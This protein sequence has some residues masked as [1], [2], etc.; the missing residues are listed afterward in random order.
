[1]TSRVKILES[2]SIPYTSTFPTHSKWDGQA[3]LCSEECTVRP[4]S[5]DIV[6]VT[7]TTG[8]LGSAILAKLVASDN[9]GRIYALNRKSKQGICL[10]ERQKQALSSRGYDPNIVLSPKVVLVEGDFMRSGLEI[11]HVLKEEAC[12]VVISLI[13]LI[14]TMSFRYVKALLIY[15][16]SVSFMQLIPVKNEALIIP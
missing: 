4:D 1:M 2:F 7:G 12:T 13:P 3:C 5:R 8:A 16:T 14:L 6:L 15:C 10:L 9:V 11:S